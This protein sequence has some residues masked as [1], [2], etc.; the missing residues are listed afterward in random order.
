MISN[1]TIEVYLGLSYFECSLD[2]HNLEGDS[3]E[4]R[5]VIG[6]HVLFEGL[7]LAEGRSICS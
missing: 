6:V 5:H 4:M 3:D 2:V 7:F 1:C